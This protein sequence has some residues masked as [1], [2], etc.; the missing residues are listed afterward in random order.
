M[1]L[2]LVDQGLLDGKSLAGLS[3]GLEQ[4]SAEARTVNDLTA[5]YRGA[6][7]DLTEAVQ[8]P[9]PAQRERSLR[10]A[11]EYVRRHFAETLSFAEVAREAGFAPN[12]FSTLFKRRQGITFERFVA[13]LRIG[14]ARQL[15]SGS[16]FGGGAHRRAFGFSFAPVLQCGIQ[17]SR[18][19][20]AAR[21]PEATDLEFATPA[22]AAAPS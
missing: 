5:L 19:R 6:V 7:S 13:D 3:E 15:L 22:Q 20:D 4:G 14:H 2:R 18:R 11:I 9:A 17:E 16:N 10:R 8:R 21:I 1:A 12:Y